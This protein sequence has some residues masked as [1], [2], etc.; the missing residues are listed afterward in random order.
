MVF[1]LVPNMYVSNAQQKRQQAFNE[2]LP[3]AL[4]SVSNSMRSG[5][6]L[7]Q[8]MKLVS[9]EMPPPMS[10]EFQR[11]VSEV[12]Y[13]LP[14]DVAFA[15]MLRRNPSSDL[16]LVVT[17]IEINLEVGG[18]L[19]EILD[20]ISSIIRDRVRIQGQVRSATAQVRFSATVLTFLPFGFAAIIFVVNPDYISL[21]W[22][23]TPG[24]VMLAI[25]IMMVTF[26]GM[27]LRRVAKIDV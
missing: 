2:Q 17:A 5:Y 19:S 8:A 20:G 7:V 12:S 18:N 6:G 10:I 16:S 13:G 25:A 22:T 21:L 24:K 1:L 14:Y 9:S 3:A 4:N 15:N 11:V 27:T 26:G 23:T